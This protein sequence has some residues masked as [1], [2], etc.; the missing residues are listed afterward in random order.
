LPNPM[1]DA[2][3]CGRTVRLYQGKEL[4][5]FYNWTTKW[6]QFQVAS[7]C[8]SGGYVEHDEAEPAWVEAVKREQRITYEQ[9]LTWGEP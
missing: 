7:D 8:S 5:G 9:D 4:L 2:P 6:R 1:A 3:R